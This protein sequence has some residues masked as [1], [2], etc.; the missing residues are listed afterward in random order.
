MGALD[1]FRSIWSNA[2]ATFGQGT[3][4]GGAQ[5]DQSGDLRRLQDTINS[6]RP[7]E[8]WMGAASESYTDANNR[9]ARTL[10]G[11]ANL[12]D[13][14]AVE[15]D[16]AAAVVTAGRRDLDSVRRW[17]NDAAARVPNNAAGERMLYPTISK[18]ASD[19]QDILTRSHADLSAIGDRIRGIGSEYQLLGEGEGRGGTTLD[20]V[21]SPKHPDT[22]LDLND[23][24]YKKPGELGPSGF[25]ELVPHSGVWVP[26]P[27][28]RFY[29]PTPVE[30][31]L[32]LDDI[33]QY[34]PFDS[35]GNRVLGP[36]GYIE[37][38][39]DS[40][41]WVPDPNGP[42]W[43]SDPP[44]AP[45]DLNKIIVV[46]PTKLGQPWE[47]ELIPHSGVWVPNPHYGGPH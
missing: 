29:V 32:D 19:I 15:V 24:V 35:K 2:N 22:T 11:I 21:P 39:P 34:P 31:P 3:P 36:S 16:R 17:V 5:F 6:A 13:R 46:D 27:S 40:G 37:L 26:D 28:S 8:V 33:V 42:M 1:G 25:K 12:D 18:G 43:P 41:T 7:D 47:V 4:S 20:K 9:Q 44:T 30:K 45:V 14:L 23:I 10:G 38:V